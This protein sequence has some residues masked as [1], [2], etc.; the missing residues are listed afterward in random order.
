M[1]LATAILG[2]VPVDPTHLEPWIILGSIAA[3]TLL[4]VLW[5]V[6]LRKAGRRRRKHRRR[7]PTLAE[8]GG[9]RAERGERDEDAP[10]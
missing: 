4:V 5:A 3:V 6:Y 1:N 10:I 7:N 8:T 9:M 2:R